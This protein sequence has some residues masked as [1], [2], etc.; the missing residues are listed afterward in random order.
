MAS[1][2]A[3]HHWLPQSY[4][5]VTG[6]VYVP[7]L[8][9]PSLYSDSAVDLKHWKP[10]L[11]TPEYNG[12]TVGGSDVPRD[13]GHSVL[14]HGSEDPESGMAGPNPWDSNGGTM[15]TAGNL[16]FQGL[17]DGYLHAYSADRGEDLWS[18]YAGVSI[19]G[20]PMTFSIDGRQYVAITAGPLN[21]ATA[22]FGSLSARWG[23]IARAA[24]PVACLRAGWQRSAPPSGPPQLGEAVVRT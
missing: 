3:V 12:I 19:T 7:T 17:A 9:M 5:P 23:W 18:F 10:V 1:F 14:K 2:Q 21:G 22:T 20:V 16:V 11:N 6:L 13:A 4:N 24:P 8:E 15:A